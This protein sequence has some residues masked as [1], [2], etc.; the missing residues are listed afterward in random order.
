MAKQGRG[1]VQLQNHLCGPDLSSYPSLWLPLEKPVLQSLPWC[2]LLL[3]SLSPFL[4]LFLYLHSLLR[5]FSPHSACLQLHATPQ[6]HFH[7]SFYY[8]WPWKIKVLGHVCFLIMHILSPAEPVWLLSDHSQCQPPRS[9]KKA[10]CKSQ[11]QWVRAVVSG[12]HTC[13]ITHMKGLLIRFWER[14]KRKYWFSITF[15][16]N[17]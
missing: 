10:C 2:L 17:H 11:H 6:F 13:S 4:W 12:K 15:N 14:G 5:T 9:R 3:C 8:V 1:K 7:L 16:M